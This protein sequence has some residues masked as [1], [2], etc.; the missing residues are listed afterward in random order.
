MEEGINQTEIETEK[1]KMLV[2]LAMD[3]EQNLCLKL[4][5]EEINTSTNCPAHFHQILCYPPTGMLT[6]CTSEHPTVQF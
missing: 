3:R 6:V 5:S 2:Q 4:S 1:M